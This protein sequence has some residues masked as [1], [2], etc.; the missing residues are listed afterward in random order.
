MKRI[1]VGFLWFVGFFFGFS[2]IL[3]ILIGMQGTAIGQSEEE[4]YEKAYQAGD[5]LSGLILMAS[6]G[7]A[8]GGTVSQKLPGT[9]E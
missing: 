3:G 7:A 9:K 2:F 5:Q 8:I 1:A 4:V 6:A